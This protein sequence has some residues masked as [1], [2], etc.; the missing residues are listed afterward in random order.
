MWGSSVAEKGHWPLHSS[1]PRACLA[2]LRNVQAAVWLEQSWGGKMRADEVKE[3]RRLGLR[4]EKQLLSPN[5]T[6][7]DYH[8]ETLP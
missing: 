6:N 4:G 3:V 7:T 2:F 5:P 1:E 8:C